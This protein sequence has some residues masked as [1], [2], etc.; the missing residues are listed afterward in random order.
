MPKEKVTP[1]ASAQGYYGKIDD[2]V[3]RIEKGVT[4]IEIKSAEAKRQ[5]IRAGVIVDEEPKKESEVKKD[6]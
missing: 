3:I 5:L 2:E 4:E 6:K 1:V